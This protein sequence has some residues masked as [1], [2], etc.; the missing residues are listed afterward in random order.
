M[1]ENFIGCPVGAG[2]DS[3]IEYDKWVRRWTFRPDSH[4][5]F[6]HYPP[7][8]VLY[9]NWNGSG[10]LF[11]KDSASPLWEPR[12]VSTS[13]PWRG[14]HWLECQTLWTAESDIHF[15]NIMHRLG[16]NLRDDLV[17]GWY[18]GDLKQDRQIT[19]FACW[20]M[21]SFPFDAIPNRWMFLYGQAALFW[22]VRLAGPGE[23]KAWA[24]EAII[25]HIFSRPAM[26]T[27]D[28]RSIWVYVLFDI[29]QQHLNMLN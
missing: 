13:R 7:F 3:T 28:L 14:M 21:I 15:M 17:S 6:G 10:R 19:S 22:G 9:A 5:C 8:V 2:Q 25:L 18:V 29:K 16:C 11:S 23:A 12:P 24:W 20:M 1:L 27:N 26:I 4:F